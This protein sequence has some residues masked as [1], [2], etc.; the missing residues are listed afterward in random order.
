MSGGVQSGQL[1]KNKIFFVYNYLLFFL[2]V[3]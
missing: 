3:I 1:E 2:N